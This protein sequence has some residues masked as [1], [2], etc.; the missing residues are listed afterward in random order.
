MTS[1]FGNLMLLNLCFRQ[2]ESYDDVVDVFEVENDEASR[3]Q[4]SFGEPTKT[5][6]WTK[7]LTP[8]EG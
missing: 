8:K 6:K 7:Y 1:N 5:S 4:T 2:E 3:R